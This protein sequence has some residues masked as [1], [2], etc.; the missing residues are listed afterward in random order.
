MRFI[1][2]VSMFN[3]EF[4]SSW[5]P[6]TLRD[7]WLLYTL[8]QETKPVFGCIFAFEDT[9]EGWMHID[10]FYIQHGTPVILAG[11]GELSDKQIEYVP[12]SNATPVMWCKFWDD[13]Y[14]PAVHFDAPA[15]GV[16]LTSFTP[17]AVRNVLSY[18][19]DTQPVCS[20]AALQC[21]REHGPKGAAEAYKENADD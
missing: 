20:E 8:G 2:L 1:K 10:D 14:L 12:H 5:A 4:R 6:A 7:P 17:D 13:G 3:N 18:S 15:C 16:F 19:G 11:E 9:E 21:L